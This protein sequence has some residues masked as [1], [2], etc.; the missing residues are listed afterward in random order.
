MARNHCG[1][2]L[3]GFE[4]AEIKRGPAQFNPAYNTPL[5]QV[6]Y[7]RPLPCAVGFRNE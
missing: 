7:G 6:G 2:H 3:L 4:C 1:G 5:T